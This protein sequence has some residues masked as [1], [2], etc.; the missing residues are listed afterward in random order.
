MSLRWSIVDQNGDPLTCLR[1]GAQA[2]TLNLR[3]RAISGGQPEVFGCEIAAGTTP[4]LP[5]GEYEVGIELVGTPPAGILDTVPVVEGIIVQ[6][7]NNTPLEPA[8]FTV[9][10]TGNLALTIN[11]NIAGGNCAGGAGITSMTLAMRE[12]PSGTCFPVTF[13]IAAGTM[14]GAPASTYT[15]S[16]CETPVAGPCIETD[17]VVTVTGLP[18][19]NYQVAV[20]G[21]IDATSCFQNNDMLAVP[22]AMATLTRTLNLGRTCPP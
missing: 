11:T 13:N 1:I 18:T 21:N 15:A 16:S 17:Q 20:R 2:V 12:S 4:V 6:S 7:E 9:N 8:V 10:A 14:S 22:P 5:V 19:N 3:S